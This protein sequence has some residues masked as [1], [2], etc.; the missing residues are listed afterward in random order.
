V[1]AAV[2]LFAME[3]TML[4]VAAIA[5]LVT[6]GGY[7][8]GAGFDPA[9]IKNGASGFLIGAAAFAYP[10]HESVLPSQAAPPTTGPGSRY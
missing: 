7:I 2:S 5:M 10:L 4:F 3:V 6:S 8:T 9:N 1:R